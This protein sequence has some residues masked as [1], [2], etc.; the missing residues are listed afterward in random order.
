MIVAFL[1]GLIVLNEDN[2]DSDQTGYLPSLIFCL[3]V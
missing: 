2:K 3:F 1:N